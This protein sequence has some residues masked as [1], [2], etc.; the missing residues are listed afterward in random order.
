[1]QVFYAL[2]RKNGEDYCILFYTNGLT[3]HP[4][5]I[6]CSHENNARKTETHLPAFLQVRKQQTVRTG[7]LTS[8]SQWTRKTRNEEKS[9]A[10]GGL[11]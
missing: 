4:E 9:A 10:A 6:R 5:A 8:M 7:E 11:Y 1:M 2:F 3:N